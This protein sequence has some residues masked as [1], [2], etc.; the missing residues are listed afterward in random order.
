MPLP[1]ADAVLT[2][3]V[4]MPRQRPIKRQESVA[5]ASKSRGEP[6]AGEEE[7]NRGDNIRANG[8]HALQDKLLNQ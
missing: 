5:P 1:S 6:D 8:P 4:R 7:C 2:N 3:G